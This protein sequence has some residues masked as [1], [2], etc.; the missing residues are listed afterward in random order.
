MRCTSRN[1]AIKNYQSRLRKRG[2][3]R[4]VLGLDADRHLI[5]S[6]AKRLAHRSARA[7][8]GPACASDF[9]RAPLH[10][11][12]SPPGLDQKT[13]P[14]PTSVTLV[15]RTRGLRF[16]EVV[17]TVHDPAS[18]DCRISTSSPTSNPEFQNKE[19]ESG[20]SVG[21]GCCSQKDHARAWPM[22]A[23]SSEPFFHFDS[24]FFLQKRV[25]RKDQTMLS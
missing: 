5:R 18:S 16:P 25:L 10:R 9:R 14:L 12:S 24:T 17:G 13:S 21:E 22:E 19:T 8:N 23:M 7:F 15:P 11:R 4:F 2:V 3:T 1:R 20:G 6:L